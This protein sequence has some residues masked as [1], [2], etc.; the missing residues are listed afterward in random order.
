MIAAQIGHHPLGTTDPKAI[1][2]LVYLGAITTA[3]A[4]ALLYAG[5]R[6]TPSGV[7]VI[8]TLIEPVAAA[9]LAVAILDEKIRALGLAGGLLILAAIASLGAAPDEPDPVGQ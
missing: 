7:A 1:S 4:Y 3:L 6:T 5:L 2:L 8:A 9:V